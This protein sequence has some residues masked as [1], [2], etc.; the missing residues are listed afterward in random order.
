MVKLLL[1]LTIVP[2]TNV[3]SPSAKVRVLFPVKVAVAKEAKKFPVP[4][5]LPNN[6]IP[7]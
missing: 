2:A 7:S 4:P 6:L 3:V 1:V 5:A